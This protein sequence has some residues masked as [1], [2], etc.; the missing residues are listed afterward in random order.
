MRKVGHTKDR[1]REDG[2]MRDEVMESADWCEGEIEERDDVIFPCLS[3]CNPD[4]Q[5]L[6]SV[7]SSL[8]LS[9]SP[10]S[11]NDKTRHGKCHVILPTGRPHVEG[12]LL[13]MT[14][15]WCFLIEWMPDMVYEWIL[16]TVC[17]WY[18]FIRLHYLVR[19]RMCCFHC[20]ALQQSRF[21]WIS[22]NCGIY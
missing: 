3:S 8:S 4:T 6:L 11:L 5:P 1:V 16:H 15:N 20:H 13:K 17:V 9:L 2:V 22:I 14:L 21:D 18:W 19:Y 12:V 7:S 10:P